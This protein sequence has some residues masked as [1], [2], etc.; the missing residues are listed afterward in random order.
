MKT[1]QS[2]GRLDADQ[3]LDEVLSELGYAAVDADSIRKVA[4]KSG[5]MRIARLKAALESIA[6]RSASET[7]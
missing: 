1:G 4:A 6:A 5:V 2:A 3:L 7:K